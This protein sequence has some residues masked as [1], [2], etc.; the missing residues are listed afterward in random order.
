MAVQRN[1]SFIRKR[2]KISECNSFSEIKEYIFIV[3]YVKWYVMTLFQVQKE[4]RRK[5]GQGK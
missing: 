3:R 2:I 4:I 1:I 5:E